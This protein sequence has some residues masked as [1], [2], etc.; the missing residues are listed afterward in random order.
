MADEVLKRDQNHVTVLAGITDDANED[1]TMLRVDPTTKRLK[2]AAVLTA[3]L[4]TLGDVEITNIQDGDILEWDSVT[5]KWINVAN[6]G[7]GDVTK[8]GTPVNNQIAVWTG[9]GTLEGT[10]DFTYDGTNLNLITGKNFQIAGVTVLADA[11]GTTTLSNIDALDAT[12][13]ATIEN[14]IDTL[15]NLTSIQGRT[16]TLSANFTLP[17]DPNADRILF[18][19]DSAGA[20]AYLAVGNSIAITLTTI[21]T[22][23]DI[24][25]SATPSFTGANLSAGTTTLGVISGTID[26]GGST[27]FEVPNGAGGTT[28]N[29]TGEVCV[30]STSRTFNFYDGTTEAV[31]NPV[32]SKSITIENPTATEDL[33]MF[34]TDDAITVTKLVFVITGSTSVTTTIRHSTDRNATG[35]EVV[36]GGTTANSTTT[37]NVVTSFND[38][39][40]PADSFVWLETTALSGT[41]TTLSVTVFY[42][43]DA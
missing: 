30:D 28:V 31:V 40:I 29:A 22:I 14:A 18:W 3:D 25:T 7:G 8:V 36:T 43:Q 39:T 13:E 1:I 2:I 23:Q 17:A 9:D 6:T 26:A 10:S 16:V 33:T 20:T 35:N 27:S 42:R 34:Y 11:A 21:D 15:A 24:R 38:A 4:S 32:M 19:D 37:G 5:S 12:T 41:P